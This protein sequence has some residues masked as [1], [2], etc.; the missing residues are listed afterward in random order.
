MI[1]SIDKENIEIGN[2]GDMFINLNHIVFS[3]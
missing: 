1:L 2:G 3:H